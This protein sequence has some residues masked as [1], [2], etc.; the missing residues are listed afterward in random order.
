MDVAI[1]DSRLKLAQAAANEAAGLI[2]QAIAAR[3][4]A[5]LIAATGASQFEFLDELVLQPNVDWAQVTFFHLDEYVGLP[6]THPA[7]FRRYLQERIVDRVQPGAFHFVNGDAL[8]PVAEC[9]RVG[10]LISRQT[11]AAAFVGIGENGHLAF[12]DPPADFYTQEPYLIVELDEGCRRQQV[13]EGWFESVDEV[14]QRA[15]SMSI[16]QILKARNVLCVV[17]DGRKAQAV[18]DT[19]ELEISPLRPASI[20]RQHPRTTIYLD[21]ESAALLKPRGATVDE[22]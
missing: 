3:G 1:F 18:R 2:R 12:N 21:L 14:P 7:S 22:H 15:I 17:P 20:L 5:Y 10:E 9:R 13:G 16:Q 19:L 6:K 4:Q 8:D 11:I